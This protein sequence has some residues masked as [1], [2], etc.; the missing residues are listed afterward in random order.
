MPAQGVLLALLILMGALGWRAQVARAKVPDPR[1][2]TETVTETLYEWWLLS[3][4]EPDRI[5][6][7]LSINHPDRPTGLDVLR[8]CGQEIYETWVTTPPCTA[9]LTGGDVTTCQGDYLH[10]AGKSKVTHQVTRI[11]PPPSV[12]LYLD[13]CTLSFP[14]FRCPDPVVLRFEGV[15]SFPGAE[16][17]AI[18][19]TVS[20]YAPF[21]CEGDTCFVSLSP[22][23]EVRETRYTVRFSAR[24][25]L[26]DASAAYRATVRLSPQGDGSVLVDVLSDRWRDTGVDWCAQ[27]WD[28][29]PPTDP[30]PA[31]LH[32][33]PAP[34]DLATD[35]PYLYLGGQLIAHGIVDASSCPDGGRLPSG[36]A[37]PCGIALAQEEVLAWQNRFDESIW[38]AARKV[39]VPATLLKRMF[40]Q[41]SQFWPAEFPQRVEV[42]FGQLFPQG[43]DT[44]LLWEPG[45]AQP[46]CDEV[47]GE[48]RCVYGYAHLNPF[49][50]RLLYESI[51]AQA[52]LSCSDCPYGVDLG[53]S[54][55]AVSLFAHLVRAHCRQIGQT[56][57]NITRRTPSDVSGYTDLWQF[58][59]ANYNGPD[60]TYEA[61]RR[62]WD[63]REPLDWAHVRQ[64]FPRGCES[65]VD[66]VETV[67]P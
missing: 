54:A 17:T 7:R 21:R 23:Q 26:G 52:N 29:L 20:G 47:L 61:L 22:K 38:Q 1:R 44:L 57:R 13:N 60:C 14:H 50:R 31:W 59:L 64:R 56:V 15:E 8:A 35:V 19:V 48:W 10:F 42:G 49:Q 66:Y 37:S 41:E 45:L 3:W 51:W 4:A 11:Y 34:A 27:A 5:L 46:L 53:R 6:C 39:G 55:E 43:I 9:A 28:L 62:T 36:A 2:R 24:S 40:A 33:P 32:T 58:T 67:A 18:T 25:S 65:V 16:I 30:L 63:A 12:N